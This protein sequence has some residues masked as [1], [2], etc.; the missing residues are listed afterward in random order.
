[1]A[2]AM[3]CM[4]LNALAQIPSPWGV[5]APKTC[6]SPRRDLA[7]PGQMPGEVRTSTTSTLIVWLITLLLL[8][9]I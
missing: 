1:M 4:A 9:D 2:R 7:M 8:L 3:G 6:V 5:L